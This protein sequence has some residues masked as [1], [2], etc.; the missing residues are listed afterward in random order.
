MSFTE[1]RDFVQ[2]CPKNDTSKN[3]LIDL[4]HYEQKGYNR[5]ARP[6]LEV[7][8]LLRAKLKEFGPSMSAIRINEE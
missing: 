7:I 8:D 1:L 4:F 2:S 5:L 6:R 3:N